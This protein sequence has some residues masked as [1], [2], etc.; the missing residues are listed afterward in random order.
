M[1]V[2]LSKVEVACKLLEGIEAVRGEEEGKVTRTFLRKA[3]ELLDEV[4]SKEEFII[5]IGY[6]IARKKGDDKIKFL[7]ALMHHLEKEEGEWSKTREN[8]RGVLE[9]TIK[10][11][12]IRAELKEELGEDLCTRR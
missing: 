9:Y 7:K 5:N 11:Y 4:D 6:M 10:I 3:F 1:I 8:L 2:V 12:T